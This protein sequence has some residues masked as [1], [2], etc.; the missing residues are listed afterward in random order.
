VIRALLSW[1]SGK[2][3]AYALHEV[4]RGGELEIE[5]LLT[6]L[7]RAY[8]R[9]SMHGVREELLDAQARVAEL[10]VIKVAIPTPCS[11]EDYEAE[12]SRVLGA[13]RDRGITHIV[14]GDLFLTD[15]RAY[16]EAQLAK[17]G[18]TAVFPLWGRDTRSLADEMLAAGVAARLTC[19][20]PRRLSAEFAGRR[21]D[22]EL[23]A[24]LPPGVDPCGENGEFHTFVSDGPMFTRPIAVAVGEIVERDGFVF[25][26]L[27]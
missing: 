22:A 9:V 7:T 26:D 5:G 4:R 1:S 3:S 20:D 21:F 6:T 23:L 8:G 16:R 24:A 18:L 11:N 10:P 2:D 27:K 15:L 17:L 25:A 12:M 14:Y 19:V 13:A